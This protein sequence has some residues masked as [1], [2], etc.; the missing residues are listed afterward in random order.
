MICNIC[1]SETVEGEVDKLM[2]C[3]KCL[4]RVQKYWESKD[5]KKY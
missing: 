5:V 1:L 2:L 3:S 4:K